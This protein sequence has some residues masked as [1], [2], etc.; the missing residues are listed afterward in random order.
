VPRQ[1]RVAQPNVH[2]NDPTPAAALPFGTTKGGLGRLE[3]T[4]AIVA[5]QASARGRGA[6]AACAPVQSRGTPLPSR[7]SAPRGARQPW[8][9]HS[10]AE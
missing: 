1:E 10:P 4:I 9:V 8:F 5:E 3:R 2:C 6:G 7:G